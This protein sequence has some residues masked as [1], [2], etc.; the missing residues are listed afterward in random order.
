M[1]HRVLPLVEE[2]LLGEEIAARGAAFLFG[3]AGGVDREA[4]E[5]RRVTPD[6]DAELAEVATPKPFVGNRRIVPV[7]GRLVRQDLDLRVVDDADLGRQEKAILGTQDDLC[8]VRVVRIAGYAIE[9]DPK[10]VHGLHRSHL[11]AR[12]EGR[13]GEDGRPVDAGEPEVRADA[14]GA[15]EEE[16][17]RRNDLE[18]G[19]QVV[20]AGAN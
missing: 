18:L 6:A 5:L 3:L 14:V 12:A 13:R 16:V 15:V 8:A 19:V 2:A 11:Q 4:V 17:R 20:E 1:R 9:N 7:P 10:Q